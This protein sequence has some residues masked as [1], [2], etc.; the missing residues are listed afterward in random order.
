MFLLLLKIQ[1]NP[2]TQNF[3]I[4]PKNSK[5]AIFQKSQNKSQNLAKF[6][7]MHKK[8]N[9]SKKNPKT[10]SSAAFATCTAYLTSL[11]T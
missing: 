4:Y 3:P 11:A 6:A 7:N 1:K 8:P 9:V 5:K 10:V 2:K